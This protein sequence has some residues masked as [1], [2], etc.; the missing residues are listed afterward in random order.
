MRMAVGPSVAIG[1]ALG[2]ENF[3]HIPQFRP[4]FGQHIAHHVVAL[5][6]QTIFVELTGGVARIIRCPTIL[7]NHREAHRKSRQV[8]HN[9][10]RRH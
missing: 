4:E 5:D 6:Q 3:G 8:R 7:L 10:Y 2:C 1:A 9:Y